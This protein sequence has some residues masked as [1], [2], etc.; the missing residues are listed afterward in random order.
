[1]PI[2]TDASTIIRALGGDG[3]TGMCRCPAHDD[4]NPSLKVS[5]GTG[6][7]V[8]VKCF[9]GC[10]QDAV[11]GSLR[12]RG[13]WGSRH[14][15]TRSGPERWSDNRDEVREE[16]LRILHAHEILRAALLSKAGKPTDYLRGRGIDLVPECA[17]LLPPDESAHYTGKRYPAMVCPISSGEGII[18][19]HPP[20]VI[21]RR[22][23]KVSGP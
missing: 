6:G 12:A 4:K 14:R 9:A 21:K 11:I 23:A 17:M 5:D 18:G 15:D 7:K 20:V 2:H 10:T 22:H 3:A 16:T 1:M 8:L 19:A 13:L